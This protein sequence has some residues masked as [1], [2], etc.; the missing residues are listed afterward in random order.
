M[1]DNNKYDRSCDSTNWFWV[2]K[3]T[4]LNRILRKS[5]KRIAVI[6]NEFGEIVSTM[7][8]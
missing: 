5:R 3:T 2:W 8:W 1:L 4:L 6:E 7:I